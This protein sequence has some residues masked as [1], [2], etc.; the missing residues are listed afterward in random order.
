MLRSVGVLNEYRYILMGYSLYFPS[1]AS[2]L[3]CTVSVVAGTPT[4]LT[5]LHEIRLVG[6]STKGETGIGLHI[7]TTC[8]ELNLSFSSSFL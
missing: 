1:S 7:F 6:S 4:L 2:S 3:E 8:M 5:Q